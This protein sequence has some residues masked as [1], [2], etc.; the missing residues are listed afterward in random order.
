MDLQNLRMLGNKIR[1]IRQIKG[2]SQD[3]LAVK[4]NVSQAAYS[5]MENGIIALTDERFAIILK[6]LNVSDKALKDFDLN[7]ILKVADF[8]KNFPS[9]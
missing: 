3:A 9:I 2:I 5:K 7:E 1:T 4:L 6:E 8:S